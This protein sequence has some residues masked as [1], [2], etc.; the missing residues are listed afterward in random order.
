MINTAE[1]LNR[2]VD[3]IEE[4]LTEELSQERISEIACCSYYD[5]GRMFSLIA[6]ISLSDYLRRRRLT[7]AGSDLK[8]TDAKVLDVALKYGYTSPTSFARAFFSF[9]GFNPG[10]SKD[11]D[12]ILTVF[13]RLVFKIEVRG[14]VE[15]LKTCSFRINGSD[16]EADYFGEAEMSSW[17][18]IY[19][20][21]QFW[22]LK[23]IDLNSNDLVRNGQ[24]LPY[25]NYPPVNIEIG[26]VFLID[27][28]RKDGGKERKYYIADGTVWQKMQCT[29]EFYLELIE[30]LRIDEVCI[31]GN[32]YTAEYFGEYNISQWSNFQKREFWR[33]KDIN[34]TELKYKKSKDVLPYNNYPSVKINL[35]DVFIIDYQDKEGNVK[36][37]YYIADGTV[38]NE[39]ASTSEIVFE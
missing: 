33:V 28:F 3:Y 11:E 29:S 13:P 35:G 26:Q 16:Y 27:Y 20:K 23:N 19:E 36:R 38:W 25:N 5:V 37:R 24:V 15:P 9:H 4:H 8:H 39:M 21:R 30:P 22:R 10:E 34:L 1:N 32:K 31:C 18:E 17:S 14:V 7:L 2:V 12:K 6:N